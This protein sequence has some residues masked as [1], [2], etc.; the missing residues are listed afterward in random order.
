MK[1]KMF[2]MIISTMCLICGVM[3]IPNTVHAN[4]MIENINEDICIEEEATGVAMSGYFEF[5]TYSGN[6]AMIT[7]YI[8]NDEVLAIPSTVE[9]NNTDYTVIGVD[10]K[11]FDGSCIKELTIPKTIKG[12]GNSLLEINTLEK[13]NVDAENPSLCSI[14]G[15]LFRKEDDRLVL[16]DYPQA[17]KDTIYVV[18]N[19]TKTISC[20]GFCKVKNLKTLVLGKVYNT[21]IGSIGGIRQDIDIYMNCVEAS[22]YLSGLSFRGL[23]DNSRVFVTR[24]NIKSVLESKNFI[25]QSNAQII[26]LESNPEY[27]IP[28]KGL[29][30]TD[31]SIIKNITVS[32]K[33]EIKLDSIHVADPTY[34]FTTDSVEWTSSDPSVATVDNCHYTAKAGTSAGTCVLTGK[35]ESGHV[36]TI[37][38]MVD[39]PVD[40]SKIRIGTDYGYGDFKGY[41]NSLTTISLDGYKT[42]DKVSDVKWTSSNTDVLTITNGTEN[43]YEQ[44]A[45]FKVNDIGS[46]TVSVYAKI[47]NTTITR[48]MNVHIIEK[49]SNV[50]FGNYGTNVDYTGKAICPKVELFCKSKKL[51]EGK[52]YTLTYHNNINPGTGIIVAE[53]IGDYF[54]TIESRFTINAKQT[55]PVEEEPT[56]EKLPQTLK[57]CADHVNRY[58]DAGFRINSHARTPISYKS[59]N[60]NVV[61]VDKKGNV[62]ITGVGTAY[63]TV[64]AKETIDYKSAIKKVKFVVKKPAVA[65]AYFDAVKSTGKGKISVKYNK[66]QYAN[67]YELQYSK[68]SKFKSGVKTIAVAKNSNKAQTISKLS[69]GKKYYVRTRAYRNYKQNGK[70]YK[71]YGKW[72]S[73][74]SVKCK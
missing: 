70:T 39:V 1:K 61:T 34:G 74:K 13:I 63:I 26:S 72:S 33:E 3:S 43:E 17:K 68:D 56:E 71:T 10:D 21:V 27:R 45:N 52:D 9:L 37:N 59:S 58:G 54:G 25:D 15:V 22:R 23:S 38:L 14:D 16:S 30:F 35:D 4:E 73:V 41:A 2:A 29:T 62:K 48:S 53:G 6:K 44:N 40:E 57:T 11:A 49:M 12:M 51:T 31:G 66:V 55:K 32:P 36:L 64:T 18:P 69:S 24:D 20:Y 19:E 28:S 46:T 7:R 42:T 65:K 67:G 8:G 5:N 50:T 47:N 60:K